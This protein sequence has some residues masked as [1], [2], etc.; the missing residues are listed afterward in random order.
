MRSH[1]RVDGR[2]GKMVVRYFDRD[3][4]CTA[5]VTLFKVGLQY[6]MPHMYWYD[7][8]SPHPNFQ[9]TSKKVRPPWKFLAKKTRVVY[10]IESGILTYP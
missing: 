7:G 1:G 10:Y 9:Q 2:L 5:A 3:R 8:R 6:I 4:F